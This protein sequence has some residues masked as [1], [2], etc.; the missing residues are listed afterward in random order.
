MWCYGHVLWIHPKIP[1]MWS[2]VHIRGIVSAA[3]ILFTPS[4]Q[5]VLAATLAHPERA[6]TLQELLAVAASG[7]GNTQQQIERLLSAGVL[8][9]EP[10]RG[11]QRS[12]KANVDYLLYPELCSILRKTF[13]V[14]DPLKRVLQPFAK[15]IE[16]A[17]VFG[18]VAKG[19]DTH[20]S[21]IDLVVVGNAELLALSEALY[22]TEQALGRAI[23][24]SL[25]EP[26]EWRELRANDPVMRQIDQGPKLQLLPD[27]QTA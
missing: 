5:R 11:R 12:I 18:S 27:A 15:Q 13:G 2:C 24:L 7:R 22:S 8:V 23:H 14:A 3:D 25:Y 6:Y 21:D 19:T 17:F 20:R 9:E 16:E 4:V 1:K 26:A 10:R